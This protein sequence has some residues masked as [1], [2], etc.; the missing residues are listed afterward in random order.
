MSAG[1][2]LMFD[3]TRVYVQVYVQVYVKFMWNQSQVFR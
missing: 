3:T 2:L 1:F